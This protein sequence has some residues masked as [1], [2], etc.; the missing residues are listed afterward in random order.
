MPGIGSIVKNSHFKL[1][2]MAGVC[3]HLHLRDFLLGNLASDRHKKSSTGCYEY[4]DRTIDNRGSRKLS[5][6]HVRKRFLGYERRAVN[7]VVR[8]RSQGGVV[9]ATNH[10]PIKHGENASEI[11]SPKCAEESV[12]HPPL[13]MQMIRGRC[14]WSLDLSAGTARKLPCRYSGA[15]QNTCDFAERHC[16][17]VVQH[18]CEP[19]G[20]C[21]SVEHHEERQADR[22][23][24]KS[25]LLRVGSNLSLGNWFMRLLLHGFLAPG[26]ARP[27]QI[28]RDAGNHCCQPSTKIFDSGGI[29]TA[30]PYPGFL[31]G[32]VRFAHRPQ[33]PVG[34]C[35]QMEPLLLELLRQPFKL[36]PGLHC[37]ETPMRLTVWTM[38]M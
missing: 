2:E 14:R 37:T 34:D 36:L 25:F 10:V 31:Y 3:N 5:F 28:E 23:R 8:G 21:Q 13:Q 33:Q 22:I 32:V 18:K 11:A 16:E 38:A 27:Q 12:N 9:G 1:S 30:E 20:R 17:D 7:L 24:E 6:L 29:S 19:L 15:T 26:R 4:P 35:P